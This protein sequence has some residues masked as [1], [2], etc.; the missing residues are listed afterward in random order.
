[1]SIDTNKY[2]EQYYHIRILSLNI[3]WVINESQLYRLPVLYK[4]LCNQNFK[5]DCFTKISKIDNIDFFLED[6][7]YYRKDNYIILQN[8][9]EEEHKDCYQD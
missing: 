5:K 4:I 8:I 6:N 7:N 9:F 1:M 3:T 2:W